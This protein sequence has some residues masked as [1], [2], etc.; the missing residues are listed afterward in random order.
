MRSVALYH[1]LLWFCAAVTVL[2]TAFRRTS[3]QLALPPRAVGPGACRTRLRHSDL[4]KNYID[5]LQQASGTEMG[6]CLWQQLHTATIVEFI[7]ASFDRPQSLHNSLK[8]L[9]TFVPR[10]SSVQ[11][12]ILFVASTDLFADSYKLIEQQFTPFHF[13]RRNEFNYFE[14]LQRIVQKSRATN[15]VI[16]SDDTVLFRPCDILGFGTLQ[17]MLEQG[18]GNT[19]VTVQ[20]RISSRDVRPP[21]V[22]NM[23]PTWGLPYAHVVNCTRGLWNVSFSSCYD[24]HIDGAMLTRSVIEEELSALKEYKEPSHPGELE[25]F[26]MEWAVRAW[27]SDLTV[28]PVDRVLMNAGMNLGTVRK[29][30]E[31]LEK[32][33]S[34]NMDTRVQAATEVL[35][36]C[37]P[38]LLEPDAYLKADVTHGSVLMK[39]CKT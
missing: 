27:W 37:F 38:E 7:F 17:S 25:G 34:A 5:F 11:V 19:K 10:S 22:A 13:F 23:L 32:N 18:L 39:P 35:A 12:S 20:L 2:S 3:W 36:G 31:D 4:S 33:I 24:R 26:W 16:M 30:R 21:V 29:D 28:I 15:F 1:R 8:A 9:E 6:K 14:L